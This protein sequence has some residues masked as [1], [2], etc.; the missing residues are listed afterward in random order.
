MRVRTLWVWAKLWSH[1]QA[2]G[3]WSYIVVFWE[4]LADTTCNSDSHT[5]II[6]SESIKV[7]ATSCDVFDWIC[8]NVSIIHI[9]AD[10]ECGCVHVKCYSSASEA[11]DSLWLLPRSQNARSAEEMARSML[12]HVF[13]SSVI[14]LTRSQ[15][16]WRWPCCQPIAAH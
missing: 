1:K 11:L 14:W 4:I 15:L 12:V 7:C 6:T 16:A 9:H 2:C 8:P 5:S 13:K 10:C 3:V